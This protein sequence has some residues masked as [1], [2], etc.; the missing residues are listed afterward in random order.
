MGVLFAM[1]QA[2]PDAS[3]SGPMIRCSACGR[4]FAASERRVIAESTGLP[5]DPVLGA[6]H[7][8]RFL[9]TRFDVAGRAI[10]PRGSAC[11]RF[12]CP[13]CRSEWDRDASWQPEPTA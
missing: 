2:D 8:L 12:A 4:R 3:N 9:P 10:D 11:A 6:G 7:A 13:H 1:Q 5:D